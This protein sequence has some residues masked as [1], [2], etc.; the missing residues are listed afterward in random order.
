MLEKTVA[1][2]LVI[3]LTFALLALRHYLLAAPSRK[4]YRYRAY[5]IHFDDGGTDWP[6]TGS[7]WEEWPGA[8]DLPAAIQPVSQTRRAD[9]GDESVVTAREAWPC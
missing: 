4:R 5:L 1:S 7:N 3:G 6:L 9:S 8:I 2:L